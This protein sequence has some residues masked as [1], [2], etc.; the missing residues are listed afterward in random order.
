MLQSSFGVCAL[1]RNRSW[2]IKLPNAVDMADSLWSRIWCFVAPI[3]FD[4]YRSF[5][6][7]SQYGEPFLINGVQDAPQFLYLILFP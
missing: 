7:F 2:T 5:G 6:Y 1:L 3:K 4:T